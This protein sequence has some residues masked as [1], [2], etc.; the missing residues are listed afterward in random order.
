[1]AGQC[2][3]G[4]RTYLNNPYYFF[5]MQKTYSRLVWGI[6]TYFAENK[7]TKAV[8]GMSGGIDSS[9]SAALAVA[10]LGRNKVHALMMPEKGVSSKG[11]VEHAVA[12]AKKL[13]I[14]YDIVPINS[15]LLPLKFPWK[16]N[17]HA[18]INS[19]AR[20]RANI[21]YN[22]ANTHDALVIGT[23]NKTE[24]KLGYFTKYGDG[25]VDIEAIGSLWKTQ[26]REMAKFLGIQK[27]II[28]K[29]PSAEL[30]PGHTDEEELG[31]SYEEID[32]VLKTNK[33]NKKI[34][35]MV[36]KN[37]HKSKMPKVI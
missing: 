28:D 19:K 16:Q 32:K 2:E 37:M 20:L 3:K 24:L 4:I 13:G 18:R 33:G 12:L 5:T 27:E 9:V 35:D 11:S 14:S 22:Y 23:S 36:K 17:M 21:L 34:L 8:I 26:V 10:A 6:K 25:A 29:K 7:F 31:A 30:Y 1:M 15:M